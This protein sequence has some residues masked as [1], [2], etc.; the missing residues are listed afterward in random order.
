MLELAFLSTLF[1]PIALVLLVL[2]LLAILWPR[3]TRILVVVAA[4][5]VIGALIMQ[6]PPRTTT[7][8][9]ETPR[10]TPELPGCPELYDQSSCEAKVLGRTCVWNP[11]TGCSAPPSPR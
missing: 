4:L 8:A 3:L 10:P 6:G 9:K 7:T 11:A 1:A 5:G 2:I